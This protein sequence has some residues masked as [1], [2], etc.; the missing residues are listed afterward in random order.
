MRSAAADRQLRRRRAIRP[1]SYAIAFGFAALLVIWSHLW[2]LR[3]PYYWD[4]AGQF[5][6]AALDLFRH[7]WWIPRS[8][9]PTIHPPAIS[10]YLAAAWRIGGFHPA[11]TRLAMLL[12]AAG[13][14]LAAFLLSIELSAKPAARPRSWPGR[15]FSP[16]RCS[17]PNPFWRNWICRRWYSPRWPCCCLCRTG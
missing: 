10:A 8:A 15:C 2:L 1:S 7:G 17:S 11:V 13:G 4:E 12:L 9:P 3:L 14:L 5:I 16:P 6:P